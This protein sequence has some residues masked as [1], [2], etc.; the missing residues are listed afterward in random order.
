[1]RAF[2]GAARTDRKPDPFTGFDPDDNPRLETLLSGE[3]PR[4]LFHV[5][6]VALNLTAT[7]RTAWNQRKAAAFT[8]TPLAC[9]SPILSPP[10]SKVESPVGCY[11]PTSLYG[12]SE[13]ET[14]RR[15]EPTGMS[16]ATAMTISGAAL[17]P[18]WGYHSSPMTAF[19]MTLFNVRLG[20]MAAQSSSGD[21]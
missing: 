10:G 20:A 7:T 17:S 13:H 5:I 4:K 8:M 6:N 19:L 11:V 14:G 12:G 1:M 21:Q 9:G 2:L 18:N 16:L 15:D 3:T